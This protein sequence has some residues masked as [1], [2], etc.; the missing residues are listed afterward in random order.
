MTFQLDK[1]RQGKLYDFLMGLPLI[2]WFGYV[3]TVQARPN[4]VAAA[5]GVALN[6]SRKVPLVSRRPRRSGSGSASPLRKTLMVL[7]K[8][9]SQSSGDISCP[10]G[11]NQPM[12]VSDFLVPVMGGPR[13]SAAA[14]RR[15][16]R[17]G[18]R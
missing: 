12:S 2:Y 10:S 16:A 11:R 7:A 5:R 8:L 1:L 14:G 18:T 9:A 3:G 17:G 15:G 4:L 13:R 6:S